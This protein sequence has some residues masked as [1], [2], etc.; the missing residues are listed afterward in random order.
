MDTRLENLEH[1]IDHREAEMGV[2]GLGYA[3]LPLAVAFA[4]AGFR[5]TG[6]D[7]DGFRVGE[8][9]AARSYVGDVSAADLRR[10]VDDGRLRATSSFREMGRLDCIHI[11]VPTPLTRTREP[12]ISQL[13]SVIEEMRRTLRSG[14]LVI[15]GSTTY[16]GTTSE[17]FL[18]LLEECGLRVGEDFALAFAP[19]RIDPGNTDFALQQIPKVVG[20]VTEA[21]T[22]LAVRMFRTVFDEVVPVSGSSSAEMVKLLENTFRMINVGLANEVAMICDRLGLDVWEVTEAA[23][24]KPYGFMKFEPGP[25]LGGHC[26][27]VDPNY[28]AWKLRSL[29][30][31]ARF[32]ELA[33][34][35]NGAMPGWVVER[36][37]RLL[38]RDKLAVNGARVL[39]LGVAYKADVA[40]TRE[41]PALDIMAQLGELGADV[42]FHDPWIQEVEVAG[43]AH[44]SVALSDE[45]LGAAHVA[46]ICAGHRDVDYGRVVRLAPRVLDTRNATAL[47]GPSPKVEKL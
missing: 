21:C 40:D 30:Y 34:E 5:V 35:I 1:L 46:V 15:L 41:S 3:G 2:V 23:A 27:P 4:Q 24:T 25:G 42:R 18:P 47:L 13:L 37:V 28:L 33:G 7:R 36:I 29:N 9:N 31:N 26:I 45:E 20:G 14:Q 43:T 19:E 44:K 11:C 12:D 6:I 22:R 10:L 16:P 38:N 8:I 39:L 32:I 17:L